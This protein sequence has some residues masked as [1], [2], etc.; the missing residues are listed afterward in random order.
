MTEALLYN[1][2]KS[3][4]NVHWQR[5]ES[6]NTGSGIPDLN[7]IY[8]DKDLP[9]INQGV[10]FWVELKIG[11]P[12][13]RPAQV[14]WHVRAHAQ[15]RRAFILSYRDELYCLYRGK[16]FKEIDS[17]HFTPREFP[18]I[19]TRSLEAITPFLTKTYN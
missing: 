14:A 12:R 11:P 18:I 7:G 4:P 1:R 3:V 8:F 16:T 9:F 15:G 5:I 19:S 17:S 6:A 2:L 10:E 13:L